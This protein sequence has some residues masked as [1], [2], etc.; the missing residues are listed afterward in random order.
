[1]E[2]ID[3]LIKETGRSQRQLAKD[4]GITRQNL[5]R[6][7]KAERLPFCVKLVFALLDVVPESARDEALAMIRAAPWPPKKYTQTPKRRKR[8]SRAS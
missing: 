7:A 5:P 3:F 4:L 6:L 2:V 1:M 8:K